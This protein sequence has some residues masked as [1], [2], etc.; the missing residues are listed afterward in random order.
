MVATRE[1]GGKQPREASRSDQ[2]LD[3]GMSIG[4]SGVYLGGEW[5]NKSTII[6]RRAILPLLLILGLKE[7]NIIFLIVH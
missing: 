1:R 6:K 5:A 4:D 3:I 7:I 2:L